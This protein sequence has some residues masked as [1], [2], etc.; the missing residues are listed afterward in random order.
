MYHRYLLVFLCLPSY[1]ILLTCFRYARKIVFGGVVACAG[2]LYI[3]SFLLLIP[4]ASAV[5]ALPALL[6][7][8]L[9]LIQTM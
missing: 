9:L 3:L 2:G 7:F 8:V 5:T 1:E 6:T 4:T